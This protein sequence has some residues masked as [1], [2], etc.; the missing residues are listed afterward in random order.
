MRGERCRK[1]LMIICTLAPD[2]ASLTPAALRSPCRTRSGSPIARS[3]A[4]IA[5]VSVVLSNGRPAFVVRMQSERRSVFI[6]M[7]RRSRC[8]R[9]ASRS[10]VFCGTEMERSSK[11]LHRIRTTVAATLP[12]VEQERERGREL[13]GRALDE[14]SLHALRPRETRLRVVSALAP[15]R[16]IASIPQLALREMAIGEVPKDRDDQRLVITATATEAL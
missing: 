5:F 2:S 16:R 14:T 13:G 4:L 6:S 11:S 10:P 15:A 3:R 1:T 8:T 12:R 7:A 9:T